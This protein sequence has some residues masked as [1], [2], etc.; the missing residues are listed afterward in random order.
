MRWTVHILNAGV[1]A[2]IE[3]LPADMQARYLRL[4]D[5]IEAHG[6]DRIG[7]PHVKHLDGKLWELR[8][9]GRDGIARVIY[10]TTAGRRVVVLHAFVKKTQK[11]PRQALE[12]ARK[13][14][15][16]LEP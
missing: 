2:E 4:A 16:E 14:L 7:A 1:E 9:T 10:V 11:T 5:L 12:T 3:A 13:R 15:K 8:I 6:L